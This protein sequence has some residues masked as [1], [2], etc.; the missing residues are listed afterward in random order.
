M[1]DIEI[2]LPPDLETDVVEERVDEAIAQSGLNVT[3]RDTLKKVPG[4]IHWHLKL[5]RNPE[6][7]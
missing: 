4:C 5:G 3:M 2:T 6:T 1:H 7:L